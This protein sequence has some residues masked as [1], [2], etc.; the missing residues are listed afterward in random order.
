MAN[1]FY[2]FI[3]E[4]NKHKTILQ[5]INNINVD[6]ECISLCNKTL[7]TKTI[8][9]GLN[10][11]KDLVGFLGSISSYIYDSSISK[12]LDEDIAHVRSNVTQ[13]V[14]SFLKDRGLKDY[15]TLPLCYFDD[16]LIIVLYLVKEHIE[17]KNS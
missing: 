7:L 5:F 2:E 4:D 1:S 11:Y 6:N 8:P 9:H 10:T 14:I 15:D 13:S 12:G 17:N 3:N 16:C